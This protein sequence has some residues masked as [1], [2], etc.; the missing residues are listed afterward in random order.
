MCL[1]FDML[2]AAIYIRG[3]MDAGPTIDLITEGF[4]ICVLLFT[5]P[6][7]HPVFV[8]TSNLSASLRSAI[9]LTVSSILQLAFIVLVGRKLLLLE[10]SLKFA[11]FG[12]PLCIWALAS[13]SRKKLASA[14]PRSTVYCVISGL[15]MWF[16]LITLH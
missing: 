12:I 13:A 2:A 3:P 14:V 10:D 7:W 1:S 9:L 16:F 4:G 8:R 15:V 6:A 11:A 5:I